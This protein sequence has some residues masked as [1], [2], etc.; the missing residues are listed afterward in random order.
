MGYWTDTMQDDVYMIVTDGWLEANKLRLLGAKASE[1]PDLKIGKL[2]Y[3]A[4]LIPPDLIIARYFAAE[5]QAIEALETD[6][7]AVAQQMEEM[8]EEHGGEE[9]LLEEAKSDAGNITKTAL[10]ARTREIW[11][12]PDFADELAVLEAYQALMDRE[13]RL[14][15]KI[16]EAQKALDAKVVTKY[17]ALSESEIK[18]LVVE[19]KWLGTLATQMQI[20]LN[21]I[22]QALTGRIQELAERYAMPLPRVAEEVDALSKRVEA[23]L[24]KMGFAWI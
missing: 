24:D 11:H 17:E 22:S 21:R 15:S 19:D 6:K 12:D 16:R 2:K 7:E 1:K 3:K 5:Q 4:D 13:S 8:A 9:G 23:H 14:N 10:K 20:E 18:T